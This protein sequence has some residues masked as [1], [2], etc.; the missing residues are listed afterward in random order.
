MMCWTRIFFIFCQMFAI[1]KMIFKM[2]HVHQKFGKKREKKILVQ[3]AII[4]G[5]VF[6]CLKLNF[7]VPASIT[8]SIIPSVERG[9]GD[10]CSLK[11][12]FPFSI[13]K[14]SHFVTKIWNCDI[15]QVSCGKCGNGLGHEFVGDGPGGKGSRFWIFSHSIKFVPK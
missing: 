14:K 10:N 15:F 12:F 13:K 8:S 7:W 2:E 3:L 1:F 6:G 5:N 11:L 9:K 4:S